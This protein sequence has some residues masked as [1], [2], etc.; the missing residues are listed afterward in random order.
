MPVPTI[1]QE[2]NRSDIVMQGKV[3]GLDTVYASNTLINDKKGIRLGKHKYSVLTEKFVRVQML[4]ERQFKTPTNLPDTVYILTPAESDACGFPFDSWL[5]YSNL[6]DSYYHFIIYGD[7]WI[8]KKIITVKKDNR[9]IKQIQ[10]TLLCDTFFTS[11][12]KR[13]R[14]FNAEEIKRLEAIKS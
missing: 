13:T 12:C 5:R 9:N 1:E 6:P 3:I 2:Y 4:V 11:V 10:E 8:E 7:K 14:S